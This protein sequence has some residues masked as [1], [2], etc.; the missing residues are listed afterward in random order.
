MKKMVF[1]LALIFVGVLGLVAWG[2][3]YVQTHPLKITRKGG[4]TQLALANKL[5]RVPDSG[6]R[7]DS[8]TADSVEDGVVPSKPAPLAPLEDTPATVVPAVEL[9]EVSY[10]LALEL[11]ARERQCKV[12]KNAQACAAGNADAEAHKRLAANRRDLKRACLA[13]HIDNC[14]MFAGLAAAAGAADAA[15]WQAR[16]KSLAVQKLARCMDA[17]KAKNAPLDPECDQAGAII[18]APK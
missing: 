17:R 7:A 1:F 11:A 3:D 10:R 13:G 5:V 8:A 4:P 18:K 14:R 15:K 16:A 6:G 12:E 2:A 9:S